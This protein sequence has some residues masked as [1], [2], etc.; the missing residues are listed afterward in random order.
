MTQNTGAVVGGKWLPLISLGVAVL[1]AVG[2]VPSVLTYI[3]DQRS[4]LSVSIAHP[5]QGWRVS[6]PRLRIDGNANHI[7][8]GQH[9]WL[10]VSP[11]A[12]GTYYPVEQLVVQQDT[13][14]A[15]STEHDIMPSPAG[16]YDITV[17]LTNSKADVL[18]RGYLDAHNQTP[19][20]TAGMP[21][22]PDGVTPE[23]DVVVNR[24]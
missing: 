1:A 15:A 16:E 11:V 9:L 14:W 22:L 18:F 19:T 23:V 2:A 10:V 3:H 13:S 21:S 24:L 8:L 7:P 5:P 12:K 17:Y 6:D 20:T 4:K